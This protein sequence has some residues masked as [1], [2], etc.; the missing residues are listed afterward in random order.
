MRESPTLARLDRALLNNAISSMFPNITLTSRTRSTSD[1][2]PLLITA[3]TDIPKPSIFRFENAWLKHPLF[4]DTTL[5]SRS[6]T[7]HR[8]DAASSMVAQAKAFRRVA[9][10]WSKQQRN[11]PPS[12]TI[13]IS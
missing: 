11:P 4:L 6:A 8:D 3:S 10:V 9:K 2:V 5:P 7:L 12:T 1:H 13:A